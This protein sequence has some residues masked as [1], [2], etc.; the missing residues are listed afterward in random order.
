MKFRKGDK[1]RILPEFLD[2]NEE[3]GEVYIVREDS[4]P[5]Q[6]GRGD[7]DRVGVSAVSLMNWAIVPVERVGIHMI[8]KLE[9]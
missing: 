6:D 1:V 2:T 8:E 3:P 5:E 7:M 4:D 9:D